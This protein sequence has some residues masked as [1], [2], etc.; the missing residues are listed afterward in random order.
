MANE[1]VVF[2]ISVH[3]LIVLTLATSLIILHCKLFYQYCIFIFLYF[4]NFVLYKHVMC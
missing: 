2:S 4:S 3:F 1:L